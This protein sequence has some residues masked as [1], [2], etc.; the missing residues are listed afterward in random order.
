VWRVEV[1]AD[2]EA[3]QQLKERAEAEEDQQARPAGQE[4]SPHQSPAKGVEPVIR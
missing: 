4:V 1:E 2:L 3:V